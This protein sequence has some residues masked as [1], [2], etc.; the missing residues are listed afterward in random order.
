MDNLT[1][2][3]FFELDTLKKIFHCID[4]IKKKYPDAKINVKV[5]K[6]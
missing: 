1:I 4:E 3:L 6:I 2:E 5:L